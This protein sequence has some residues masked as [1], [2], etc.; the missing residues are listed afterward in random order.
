MPQ[1]TLTLS[2][3]MSSSLLSKAQNLLTLRAEA[4]GGQQVL[5]KRLGVYLLDKCFQLISVSVLGQ[6]IV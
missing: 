4:R 1:F 6:E 2:A 3:L 5:A